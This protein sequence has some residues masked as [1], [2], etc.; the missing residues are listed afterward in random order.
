MS[1]VCIHCQKLQYAELK[2]I[3]NCAF[4]LNFR[5]IELFR[6]HISTQLTTSV[7]NNSN[8]IPHLGNNFLPTDIKL[9]SETLRHIVNRA[10]EEYREDPFR[11]SIRNSCQLDK[12][13]LCCFY[14]HFKACGDMHLGVPML[15]NRLQ[16][17]L[18]LVHSRNRNNNDDNNNSINSSGSG[19]SLLLPPYSVFEEAVNRLLTHGMIKKVNNKGYSGAQHLSDIVPRLLQVSLVPQFADVIAALRQDPFSAFLI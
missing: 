13:I 16:D 4:S 6:D 19:I 3:I 10:A 17:F 14:I 2:K 9:S 15:W 5:S 1:K 12:A 7:D 18:S 11:A 8:E